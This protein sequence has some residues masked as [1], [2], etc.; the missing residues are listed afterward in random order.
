MPAVAIMPT[1]LL[2]PVVEEE[3]QAQQVQQAHQIK[4]ATAA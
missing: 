3:V 1:T 2:V 4:A